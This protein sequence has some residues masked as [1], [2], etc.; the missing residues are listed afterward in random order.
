MAARFAAALTAAPD[1]LAHQPGTGTRRDAKAAGL[2][3]LRFRPIRRFP[4]L[5][6]NVETPG[7]S[8]ILRALHAG[9]DIPQ[10]QRE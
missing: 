2:P 9:R 3:D 7:G 6:F 10:T 4:N 8:D 5:I 1:L